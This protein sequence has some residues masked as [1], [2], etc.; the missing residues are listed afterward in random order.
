MFETAVT[1]TASLAA[2]FIDAGADV[3]LMIGDDDLGYGRG[4]SH[5]YFMLGRLA[6]LQPANADAGWPGE[7]LNG[8][9]A[10][11][12]DNEFKIL[13]T[14]A[15]REEIPSRALRAT[16]VFTFAELTNDDEARSSR[17]TK[18]PTE[19]TTETPGHLKIATEVAAGD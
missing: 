7:Y 8:L 11:A 12:S 19:M 3:R 13:I 9:P 15:R 16:E 2:H 18:S 6:R 14:P 4:R 5:C 10:L 17:Q 1:M